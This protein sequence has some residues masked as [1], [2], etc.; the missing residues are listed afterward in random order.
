[1]ILKKTNKN[2]VLIT[3]SILLLVVLAACGSNNQESTDNKANNTDDNRAISIGLDP[4]DYST[5][6]AYLSQVILEEEGFTVEIVEAD[7]GVL[8]EALSSQDIDAFID[9]WSPNLHAEYLE[10]YGDTIVTAG[11]LF[12]DMPFGMGVPS[13]MEEINT[14]QDVADNPELFDHEI[15]A[16]EPGSG[17]A[18]TTEKM[19]EDYRMD[20]FDIQNSSVAAMLQQLDNKIEN[21]EGIVFNAWRP[22]PMFVR[23]DIK[24]LEDPRDSWKKDDV[25]IGVTPDFENESPTAFTLFS[26]MKLDLDMVE[27]WIMSI[28]EDGKEPRELAEEWVEANNEIVNKWLEK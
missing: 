13:Y 19:K 8:Y 18:L 14:I 3:L 6:P 9:I 16:I 20:E 2:F 5:V 1:M 7:T 11:T 25:E 12:N 23:H 17:M 4:Y 21:E 26:N 28:D 15:Y 22:H 10:K 24:L 27:D